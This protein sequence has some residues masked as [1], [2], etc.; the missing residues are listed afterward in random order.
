MSDD[1]DTKE[2][3]VVDTIRATTD[4][5]KEI[6]IYQDAIQPFAKEAGKALQTIGKVVNAALTPACG[7]VWGIGKIEHFVKTKVTEKLINVPEENIE[8]P[9]PTV[10]GPALEALK[11]TGHEETLREMYANLLANALDKNTKKDAHPSFVEIIKQLSSAEAELLVFLSNLE[12]YPKVCAYENNEILGGEW[13][14]GGSNI[15][16]NTVKEEFFTICSEY[17]QDANVDSSLDNF[18]RLKILDVQTNTSQRIT[19]IFSGGGGLAHS[20]DRIS[21][22]IQIQITHSE[23]LYFT[24]F[25]MSFIQ[26]C[27]KDKT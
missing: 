16:S 15:T 23:K 6:P 13:D 12:T 9:S 21:D 14:F 25:G 26:I 20:S 8:V 4:L 27:V 10:V 11:Y 1:N 5:V 7:L 24:S 22:K 17:S 19:D 2:G 18:L 3:S